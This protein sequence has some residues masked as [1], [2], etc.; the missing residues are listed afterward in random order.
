MYWEC[1]DEQGISVLYIQRDLRVTAC[2][3]FLNSDINTSKTIE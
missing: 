3:C 1:P 2:D